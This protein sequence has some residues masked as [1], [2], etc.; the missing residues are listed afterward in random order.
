[1]D[2]A[3][4]EPH[5]SRQVEMTQNNFD[6]YTRFFGLTERPFTLTPN[7]RFL[8]WSEHHRRAFTMLEYGL[9]TRAPITLL[10]GEVGAG[11]STLLYQLLDQGGPEIQ[12]GLVS[13]AQRDRGDLMQWLFQALD[14]PSNPGD[15]HVDLFRRFQDHLISTYSKGRRVVLVFDEAQNLER[16]T[17]EEL[18]MLTNINSGDNELLQLILVG[19]PELRSAI[20]QPSLRQFAQRV[21]SSVHLPAMD[22]NSV[23]AY[24]AHRLE[25]AGAQARIFDRDASALIAESTGCVPRLINQLADVALLYAY[26]RDIRTVD[27]AIVQQVLSDGVFFGVRSLEPPEDDRPVL[28]LPYAS[29]VR[30]E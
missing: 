3:T 15:G 17:L 12:F 13:N 19:Q 29:R 28:F 24:I 9:L 7:P 11:K 21:A 26:T 18:R 8:Y 14:L 6:I 30:N 1:M 10:T 4:A 16:D 5:L 22:A 23:D 2:E 20:R 25:I 27:R